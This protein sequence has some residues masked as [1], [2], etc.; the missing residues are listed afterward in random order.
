[1]GDAVNVGLTL[2]V[3]VIVPVGVGDKTMVWVTVAV[4]LGVG[5]ALIVT[6][7][8]AVDVGVAV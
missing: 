3:A 7:A 8:V 2:A 4:E 5:E 1:V 6:D